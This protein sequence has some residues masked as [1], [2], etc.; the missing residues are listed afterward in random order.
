MVNVHKYGYHLDESLS[1]WEEVRDLT[2][3]REPVGLIGRESF[4]REKQLKL[5]VKPGKKK[6]EILFPNFKIC[7]LIDILLHI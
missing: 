1:K 3:Q 7:F 5:H 4:I 2:G 6:C